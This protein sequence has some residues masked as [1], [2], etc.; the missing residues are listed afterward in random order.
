MILHSTIENTGHSPAAFDSRNVRIYFITIF[1]FCYFE[2]IATGAWSCGYNVR[3]VVGRSGF[4]SLAESDQKTLKS[5]YSQFLCLTFSIKKGL[6][7]DR[8]AS[9]LVVS[10]GKTLNGISSIFEWLDW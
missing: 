8:S 10:L 3:L 2:S 1:D 7:E 6:C 4:D 5:W 9:S